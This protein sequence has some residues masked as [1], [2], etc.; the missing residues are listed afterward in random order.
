MVVSL[1][2]LVAAYYLDSNCATIIVTINITTPKIVSII[3]LKYCMAYYDK[4]SLQKS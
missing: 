2:V 1:V 3:P 4:T